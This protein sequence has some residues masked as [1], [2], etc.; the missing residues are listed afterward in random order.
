MELSSF[1][2][3]IVIETF[4]RNS[5]SVELR[6]NIDAITPDYHA[7][8]NERLKPVTERHKA[9]A[10]KFDALTA[11]IKQRA[12]KSKK[13]DGEP[14]AKLSVSLLSMEKEIAEIKREAFAERLSCPVKLPDGSFTALLKGWSITENGMDIVPSKENLMRLPAD[15]VEELWERCIARATTVK[16]TVAEETIQNPTTPEITETGSQEFTLAFNAPI[17]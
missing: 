10:S 9:L 1:S 14:E 8:L 4:E 16:K 2:E 15:L 12:K 13:R 7:E 11:E 5:E 17:M 3:N 6:V